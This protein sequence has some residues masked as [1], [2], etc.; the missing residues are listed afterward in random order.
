MVFMA[1]L[2]RLVNGP[3]LDP[4]GRVATVD[5]EFAV[6]SGRVDLLAEIALRARTPE[7]LL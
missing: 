4:T 2:H 3:E 1:F 6:G 7:G 5:R